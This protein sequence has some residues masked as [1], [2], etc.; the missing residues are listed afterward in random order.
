MCWKDL[1]TLRT[2]SHA[3]GQFLKGVTNTDTIHI[4]H[5]RSKCF[6]S[7][8]KDPQ[9]YDTSDAPWAFT[10]LSF[11]HAF[12]GGIQTE[13]HTNKWVMWFE[14]S[15]VKWM[16]FTPCA[17]V[18]VKRINVTGQWE[19]A[20]PD[21]SHSVLFLVNVQSCIVLAKECVDCNGIYLQS[22]S[23]VGIILDEYKPVWGGFQKY[24]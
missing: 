9:F 15:S 3:V 17:S 11:H 16:Q 22:Q 10:N 23:I 13:L 18:E 19:T 14:S 21:W 12:L 7:D 4:R 1:K 24:I 2:V 20:A 8:W 6:G 5:V